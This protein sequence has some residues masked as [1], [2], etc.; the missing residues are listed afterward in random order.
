VTAARTINADA[1][2]DRMRA[3]WE[4]E[5]SNVYTSR[6]GEQW[7]DLARTFNAHIEHAS[8]SSEE[9]QYSVVAAP[10]GSGKTQGLALYSTMLSLQYG[11]DAP[12]VLIVTRLIRDA[13]AIAEQINRLAG[14]DVALAYHVTARNERGV[15]LGHVPLYPVAVI[16]HAAYRDALMELGQADGKSKWPTLSAYRDEQRALNVID[17]AIDMVEHEHVGIEKLKRTLANIPEKARLNHAGA[18]SALDETIAHMRDLSVQ[19]RLPDA[20]TPKLHDMVLKGK[21]IDLSP[22]LA[23]LHCTRLKDCDESQTKRMIGDTLHSVEVLWRQWCFFSTLPTGE[24]ALHTARDILPKGSKGAVILDAT[25]KANR[26]YDLL[27]ARIVRRKE[28]AGVRSWRNATLHVSR[29]HKVGKGFVTADPDKWARESIGEVQKA[30]SGL[31]SATRSVL[32]IGHAT[33]EPLLK[34][35]APD[36][37]HTAHWGA[38]DGSNEWRD[39]DT[40]AILSLPFRPDYWATNAYFALTGDLDEAFLSEGGSKQRWSIKMGQVVSDAVQAIGRV[41]CRRVIDE[42]GNCAPTDVFLLL[43]G[44]IKADQLLAGIVAELPGIK[45]TGWNYGST[46][47]RVKKK[48]SKNEAALIDYCSK[49]TRGT[50]DATLA[51][52]RLNL[53]GG[54]WRGIAVKLKDSS[55][56]IAEQLAA[57]N[58]AYFVDGPAGKQRGTFLRA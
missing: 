2:H 19:M 21:P 16:T 32:L 38:I 43:P 57:L 14:R 35:H 15:K 29:G 37:W 45:V 46:G 11:E 24:D 27:G 58:V 53:R 1:F 41:R 9:M 28:V 5:L 56:P 49:L 22:L 18:V 40:V 8:G 34:K 42:G 44:G 55:S 51:R 48:A 17:E 23:E 20:G 13:D 26:L 54:S 47:S 31:G 12:G 25:S 10:L 7:H 39:C 30:L 52:Q 36:G 3:H 50:H 6:L 4:S 33:G